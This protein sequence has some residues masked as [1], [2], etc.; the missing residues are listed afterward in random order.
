[1]LIAEISIVKK[2]DGLKEEPKIFN[3]QSSYKSTIGFGSEINKLFKNS[4]D[5]L[6]V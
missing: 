1:M 6:V 4:I 3:I 5:Q 2:P